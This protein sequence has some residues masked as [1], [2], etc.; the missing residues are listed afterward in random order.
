M[1]VNSSSKINRKSK[2]LTMILHL[3]YSLKTIFFL[4][5]SIILIT[6]PS[7][8]AEHS[9]SDPVHC[10]TIAISDFERDSH[11]EYN[12]EFYDLS[13]LNYKEISKYGKYIKSHDISKDGL[14]SDDIQFFSEKINQ[15]TLVIKAF[16][17]KYGVEIIDNSS[18]TICSNGISSSKVKIM[19]RDY[20]YRQT[21]TPQTTVGRGDVHGH[22]DSLSTFA[23]F[24]Q[25]SLPKFLAMKPST[26]STSKSTTSSSGYSNYVPIEPSIPKWKPATVPDYESSPPNWKS[27][28]VP[29]YEWSPPKWKPA[30]VPDYESSPKFKL[31]TS[32]TSN[33]E[34]FV[35]KY[36]SAPSI[37]EPK[38]MNKKIYPNHSLD[39]DIPNIGRD[40]AMWDKYGFNP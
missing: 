8:Y 4:L 1:E 11:I 37:P 13:E 19:E 31:D 12:N 9:L 40:L 30:T 36:N 7:T 18:V 22:S 27:A 38:Y 6:V 35:N 23:S 10:E 16:A 2:N 32:H 17:L 25:D 29:D 26:F 5:L 34:K 28:T 3:I 14:N 24:K 21:S 20:E 39:R 33:F 15:S